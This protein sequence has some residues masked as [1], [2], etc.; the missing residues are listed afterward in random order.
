MV[1]LLFV[2]IFPEEVT[3]QYY[4]NATENSSPHLVFRLNRLPTLKI[5]VGKTPYVTLKAEQLIHESIPGPRLTFFENC[6]HPELEKPE[7]FLSLAQE[8][9][10]A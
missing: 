10:L 1:A 7:V 9:S 8:F 5:G 3:S 2:T 4:R 6:G